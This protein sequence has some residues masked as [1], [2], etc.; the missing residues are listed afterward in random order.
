MKLLLSILCC[1]FLLN[2]TAQTISRSTISPAHSGRFASFDGTKIYYEVY[3]KGN[4]VVLLHGFMNTG[5]TLKNLPL[6]NAL[7]QSGY[8]LIVPDLRGNGKSDKPHNRDAY[9]HD[10]EAKDI[11]RLMDALKIKKYTV[12]GYSRGAIIASRLLILDNNAQNGIMGG[13]GAAFTDPNWPRRIMFYHALIGDSVPELKEVVAYVKKS[14]LDQL[15]LA[16]QQYGQPSTSK[17]EF[18]QLK[19]PVLVICGN[20]DSADGKGSELAALI[21][22]AIFETV[23]G[24]HTQAWQSPEFSQKI[25]GFL[26]QNSH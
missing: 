11:M 5:N 24:N 6:F 14:G 8:Q 10:A 2:I 25:I 23:P 13:M 3:G 7:L 15:S 22:N 18:S 20:E 16:F 4:P 12:F 17:E 21:P 1:S 26:K 9:L 19:K